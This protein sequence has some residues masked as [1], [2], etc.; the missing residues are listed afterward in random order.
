MLAGMAI[1]MLWLGLFTVASI[2]LNTGCHCANGGK[3]QA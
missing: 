1:L 2:R 3:G